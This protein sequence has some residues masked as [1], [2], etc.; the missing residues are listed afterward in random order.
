MNKLVTVIILCF[1]LPSYAEDIRHL[2]NDNNRNDRADIYKEILGK[3]YTT[4][5]SKT[6]EIIERVM[7]DQVVID[8][9]N[10]MQSPLPTNVRFFT[11]QKVTFENIIK[12]M[13]KTYRFE[14]IFNNV[15]VDALD[16][17]VT[18]NDKHNSLEEVLNYLEKE[19]NTKITVWPKGAGSTI[20][21]T[22]A[23]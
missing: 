2:H 20:M 13:A 16:Y 1:V 3:D 14:P 11:S 19:T 8:Q 10:F 21:I 12:I 6:E 7:Q 17:E 15:T 4:N 9:M 5:K 22:G 18:I 23:I